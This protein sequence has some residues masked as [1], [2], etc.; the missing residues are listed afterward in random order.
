VKSKRPS[1]KKDLASDPTAVVSAMRLRAKLSLEQTRKVSAWIYA[2]HAFRNTAVAFLNARRGARAGWVARHPALARDWIPE[3]FTGSDTNACSQW[4]TR[5][6]EKTRNALALEL[7]LSPGLGKKSLTAAQT[8]AWS[9]LSRGE[10]DS[11]RSALLEQGLDPLWVLLPRTVLEQTIQDLAKTTA[12]A[13]SDRAENK[14]RKA[15]GLKPMRAAGFPQ[16][17]KFAYPNSLRFQIQAEKNAAY[18]EAW[19]RKELLIPGLGRLKIRESGYAW[20]ATPPK[21][22]TLARSADGSWHVSFVCAP[23]QARCARQ[24]RLDKLGVAWEP[25]P[26]DSLTGL[27]AIEGLDMSL[28]DKAV[29]NVHG[30]L[31]RIRYLKRC[32]NSLR[33]RNQAVARGQPGSRRNRKATRKLGA[34]HVQ[35]ANHRLQENRSAAQRV[36]ERSAIVCVETLKLGFMQKNSRLAQSIADLGW[37]QFLKE[38]DQQMAARGHLL[39]YAGQF[40]PT[41]QTCPACGVVNKALKGVKALKIR[42]WDCAHCHTHH[43]RD[44]AA[45]DNIQD[46]AIERFLES[47]TGAESVPGNRPLHPELAAFISRGGMTAFQRGNSR[48]RRQVKSLGLEVP[49]NRGSTPTPSVPVRN[50]S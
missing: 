8:A 15:A 24:R 34:L 12:K 39:L 27:P 29:S 23:G 43:D 4:L 49:V 38:L 1:P 16:F 31:G 22:V 30:N 21:L 6:L 7:G 36:A 46:F 19:A 10:R 28:E 42:Q 50:R 35:I 11:L 25:L 17:Q 20:P 32:A 40:D 5:Q 3:E 41:T 33:F 13:I 48:E 47:F 37:G 45:A 2:T 9:R 14:R 18:R 26:F 44:L